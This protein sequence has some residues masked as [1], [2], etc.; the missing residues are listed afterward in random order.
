MA[1]AAG[2]DTTTAET[3]TAKD[4]YF[5]SYAHFGIHGGFSV[6]YV[7]G[8]A[9]LQLVSPGSLCAFGLLR[10]QPITEEM[11]KDEV[12]T[13][14]YRKVGHDIRCQMLPTVCKAYGAAYSS[15]ASP[16]TGL[17]PPSIMLTQGS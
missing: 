15:I 14:T 7:K 3:A 16:R 12:R 13:M 2:P 11:L 5:D 10:C 4:Y 6:P 8:N 17:E 1:A 9:V